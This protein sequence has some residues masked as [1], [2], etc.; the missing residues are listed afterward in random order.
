M[1]TSVRAQAFAAGR[2]ATPA[3]AVIGRTGKDCAAGAWAKLGGLASRSTTPSAGQCLMRTA[4]TDMLRPSDVLT[5]WR[6]AGPRK[7]FSKDAAFDA[8][9]RRRWEPTHFAAARR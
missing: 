7:W 9:I 6:E 1:S 2:V 4:M 8:E 3:G 5:F